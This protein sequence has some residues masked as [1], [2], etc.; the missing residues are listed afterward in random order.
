LRDVEAPN[1]LAE[2]TVAKID[3][4]GGG[5]EPAISEQGYVALHTFE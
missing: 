2:T 1:G 3:E 5:A 4:A